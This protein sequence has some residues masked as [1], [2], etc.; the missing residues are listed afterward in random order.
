[1][2]PSCS[3]TVN[4]TVL[5]ESSQV[6]QWWLL[7]GPGWWNRW[8]RW[9]RW[10][11]PEKTVGSPC[12]GHLSLVW[13]SRFQPRNVFVTCRKIVCTSEFDCLT[14][15]IRLYQVDHHLLPE[16]CWTNPVEAA[17]K[18]CSIQRPASSLCRNS[19]SVMS[20]AMSIPRVIG[21]GS[22]DRCALQSKDT[23]S[24][25]GIPHCGL[26]CKKIKS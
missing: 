10:N 6:E 19:S 4:F 1:M 15:F 20:W 26:T 8:K 14:L 17:L 3:W 16:N 23:A 21:P 7:F 9:K 25:T 24:K 2:A 11:P 18:C 12:L 13:C 5:L 22:C